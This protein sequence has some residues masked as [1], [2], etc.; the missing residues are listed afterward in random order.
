MLQLAPLAVAAD[1]PATQPAPRTPVAPASGPGTIEDVQRALEER[2]FTTT[3]KTA[4][5]LLGLR[6]RAGEGIS[7][8]QLF[9]LK[10]EGQI[11]Q[12]Q[13]AAAI[14]SLQAALKETSDPH[15][16]S[17]TRITTLLLRRATG[18]TYVPKTTPP[19][20]LKPGPIDLTD[21]DKRKSAFA[22][23]LDDELTALRPKIKSANSSQS[24]MVIFPVLKQVEDL[25]A[26]DMLANGNDDK[27]LQI[28]GGLVDHA[29]ML[30]TTALKG[31]WQRV[32]DIEKLATQS[33]PTQL[34]VPDGR[35]GYLS[36]T[37]QQK[38][39]LSQANKRELTDTISSCEQIQSAASA[40]GPSAKTDRGWAAITS[41][42]TRVSARARDVLNASYSDN[43]YNQSF[44]NPGLGGRTIIVPQGTTIPP[45]PQPVTTTPPPPA[46]KPPT[47]RGTK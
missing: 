40:F 19:D 43:N 29:R 32:D 6:G 28:T 17:L 46:A 36:R 14:E 24:L 47:T 8:F 3:V 15:E 38:T 27:T 26:L 4:S 41:D 2:D 25:A 30:I 45:A 34:N 33:T 31:M 37:T 44:P 1:L 12:K 9:M 35:G 7:R 13:P 16:Q 10:A 39:G 22:A 20:G 5:R 21:R 42:A 23:L 11:G 18:L